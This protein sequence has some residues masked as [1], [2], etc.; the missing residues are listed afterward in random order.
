M[1]TDLL[2]NLP[3]GSR[4]TQTHTAPLNSTAT[5]A[6]SSSIT[7]KSTDSAQSFRSLFFSFART[8]GGANE[9]AS[10]PRRSNS[11]S[12]LASIR[13]RESPTNG[14]RT[15]VDDK[16][17]PSTSGSRTLPAVGDPSVP[18]S[19]KLVDVAKLESTQPV[20]NQSASTP[21]RDPT[22]NELHPVYGVPMVSQAAK[23]AYIHFG[24]LTGYVWNSSAGPDVD[25]GAFATTTYR[26]PTWGVQDFVTSDGVRHRFDVGLIYPTRGTPIWN[27]MDV[28]QIHPEV[29]DYVLT[30]FE[31]DLRE[32]GIPASA[33][34]SVSAIRVHGGTARQDWFVDVLRVTKPNGESIY[35]QMN[36]AM[37]DPRHVMELIQ[38]FV[39]VAIPT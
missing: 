25:Q 19:T 37:R 34:S 3:L 35:P 30:Q 22:K 39:G 29:E 24:Q 32:A 15:A 9:G 21:P 17:R 8:T 4:V 6:S 23:D 26:V 2:Y 11:A 14:T 31:K 10:R 18:V 13:S 7:S 38:D 33:I 20:T 16:L 1:L 5:S 27:G 28:R 12:S 36:V